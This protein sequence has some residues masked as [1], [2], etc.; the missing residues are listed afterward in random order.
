MAERSDRLE[1][2]DDRFR[3]HTALALLAPD[4]D[5]DEAARRRSDSCGCLLQCVSEFE[6][7]ERVDEVKQRQSLPHLVALQPADQVPLHLGKV[8]LR[9]LPSRLLDVV[10]TDLAGTRRNHLSYAIRAERLCGDHDG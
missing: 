7:I 2:P 9:S 3:R 8:K 1:E 10:F 4:V 5:L 6:S